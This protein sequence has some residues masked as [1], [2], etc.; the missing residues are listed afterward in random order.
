MRLRQ[1]VLS[2]FLLFHLVA[3]TCWALPPNSPLLLAVRGVIRPYMLWTGLFQS[4]DTFAPAPKIINPYLEATII[5]HDGSQQVW[6]FPRMEQLSLLQR[7]AKERYRKFDENLADNK[8]TDLRPDVARHLA[9]MFANA[10]N[11]PEIIMLIQYWSD[12]TLDDKPLKHGQ[13]FFVY[14]V[15]PGDLE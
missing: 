6:K 4:W 13:V 5:R 9:R 8:G 3:I 2:A 12:I 14:R 11:P 10:A 1:I 7:Y 15:Q